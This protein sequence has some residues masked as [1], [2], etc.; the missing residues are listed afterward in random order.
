[1]RSYFSF[2]IFAATLSYEGDCLQENINKLSEL[3]KLDITPH[4]TRT[5]DGYH[6]QMFRCKS[7][8]PK[9]GRI[10]V[11]VLMIHGLMQDCDTYLCAGESHSLASILCEEGYD[12]WLC[13]NRGTKYSQ[14]HDNLSPHDEEFWDFCIDDLATFD[15]PAFID[16]VKSETNFSK[17]CVGSNTT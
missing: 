1:M 2:C 13:N 12:V 17:V 11:P 4:S 10:A 9:L 16:Y 14:K 6:L 8:S 5:K 15:V 7:R 3:C